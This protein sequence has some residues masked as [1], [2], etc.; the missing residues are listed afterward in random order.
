LIN[1][2]KNNLRG[3]RGGRVYF[4]LQVIDPDPGS[5]WRSSKQEP[6]GRN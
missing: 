5:Q 4:S 3:E 1:I 2:T 6:G